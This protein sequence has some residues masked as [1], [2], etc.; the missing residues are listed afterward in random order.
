MQ[1]TATPEEQG[2][3]EQV[4]KALTLSQRGSYGDLS[5]MP[6][7][8]A[9]AIFYAVCGPRINTR[10]GFLNYWREKNKVDGIGVMVTIRDAQGI[11]KVRHHSRLTDMTGHYDLRH[12]L[13]HSDNMAP[14]FVGSMELEFFSAEDLKFQFPGITVFYQ[15]PGGISYVHTNQRIY[16]HA[17]D[18][19]RGS[20]LNAWQTGFDVHARQGP[21]VFVVNGPT[22]FAGGHASLVAIRANG[23]SYHGQINLPAMASYAV[24]NWQPGSVTELAN[25]L[26]SEPGICKLDL[27]LQD[28]HLRLGVGH[29]VNPDKQLNQWLSITHSFF[30]A[31]EQ[32][33]YFSTEHL[34]SNACPAFIPFVLPTQLDVDLILYPIYSRCTMRLSLIG[35]DNEGKTQ[36]TLALPDY[37][38]PEDGIRRLVV[39]DL[40]T[41]HALLGN[42]SLYVLRF[43][44]VN[45]QLLPNRI[46]YGLNF[47]Q[48]HR[49]GTN[50]SASAYV[51]RSWGIGQRSWKW[52]AVALSEGG[53]NQV[54]VCAYRNASG[55]DTAEGTV[56]IYDLHGLVVKKTFT[57][58]D[59]TACTF[60]A[61]ALLAEVHYAAQTDSI[62]WYVVESA[63]AWLDV[64]GITVSAQGNVGGDHSF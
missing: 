49:L 31:N 38:T 42:C 23:D 3:Y 37:Q 53:Y 57:L 13:G 11:K 4:L 12:L 52:G 15:T 33:D 64:V 55:T 46:T 50:I 43:D 24:H 21:F 35:Y 47:H 30:D 8:R 7:F 20:A 25:F 27:P 60:H 19:A 45:T 40:L 58:K 18:K 62:L 17:E 9:S 26:G 6:V 54:M 5:Y 56:A 29:Y 34:A 61:E 63:Q 16:N 44:P 32:A 41:Q 48:G 10:V 51:A 39:R 14:D 1:A 22:E 59:C 2:S 28:V 36:F